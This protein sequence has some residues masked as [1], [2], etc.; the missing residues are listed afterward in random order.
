MVRD[1][2]ILIVL[3][4]LAHSSYCQI[5]DDNALVRNCDSPFHHSGINFPTFDENYPENDIKKLYEFIFEN[6][7]YPETAKTD[8]I[9]GTVFVEFWVDTNGFTS[10]HKVVVS[11]RQDLDD[12]ALRVAKLIKFDMPAHYHN[13]KP[14]GICWQFPIRFFLDDG[15]KPL[16]KRKY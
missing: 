4:L 14:I 10:E 3:L 12:E 8:K 5:D 11:V 1:H 6:L 16:R 7:T 13:G 9:E 2:V 15:K